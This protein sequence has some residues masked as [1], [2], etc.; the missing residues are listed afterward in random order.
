MLSRSWCEEV[1]TT[2]ILAELISAESKSINYALFNQ[3]FGIGFQN[4][5]TSNPIRK[6][7]RIKLKKKKK[8]LSKEREYFWKERDFFLE[9][10]RIFLEGKRI[11]LEGMRIFLEG[12][13]FFFSN[14]REYFFFL[15]AIQTR[16]VSNFGAF[17]YMCIVN[18]GCTKNLNLPQLKFIRK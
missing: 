10:T 2:A 16:T 18:V 6:P 14:K 12:T 7:T 1:E 3:I 4:S 8:K 15:E 11:F 17:H 5:P 13:R 9:Q